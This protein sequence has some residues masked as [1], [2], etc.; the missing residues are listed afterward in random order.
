[1]AKSSMICL[2]RPITN[3]FVN[4]KIRSMQTKQYTCITF[5]PIFILC[6]FMMSCGS[7]EP[8]QQAELTQE[9]PTLQALNEAIKQESKNAEVYQKRAAY[10]M[11]NEMYSDAVADFILCIEN[12]SARVECWHELSEA[13]L[14]DNRSRLAVETLEDY[15]RLHPK[16]IPTL[17][18]IARLQTIIERYA[19]AHLNLNAV[20]KQ[21]PT[22]ARALLHKGMIYRYE[23]KPLQAVEYLQQAI[24]SDP[25]LEDGHITLGQIFEA[26]GNPTAIKYFENAVRVAPENPET[27]LGLANYLWRSDNMDQALTYYQQLN[28]AH[29][30]FTR[31]HFNKGLMYLEMDSIASAKEAFT[32][33]LSLEPE[34]VP[35][36]YY[37]GEALGLQ[38]D[39]KAAKVAL[40]KALVFEPSN[41]KIKLKL[42]EANYHLNE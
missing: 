18:K 37:L 33:I 15:L 27:T 41:E 24:Q 35:A 1:M 39:W 14:A 21:D 32:Y 9:E 42:T 22:H 8:A 31:A 17:L 3:T 20:L 26:A 40:E 7:N 30:T 25:D 23:D 28:E 38:G 11:D 16:D 2:S 36:Q 34:N 5:F 13:Y 29:P 10:Y 12:D 4:Q 6:F 19:A